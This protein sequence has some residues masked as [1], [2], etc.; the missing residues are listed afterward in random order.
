MGVTISKGCHGEYGRGCQFPPH[1]RDAGKNGDP[2]ADRGK[3][4]MEMDMQMID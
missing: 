4:Y 3:T 1:E 2:N